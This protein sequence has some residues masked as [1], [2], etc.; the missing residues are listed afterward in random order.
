MAII[1]QNFLNNSVDSSELLDQKNIEAQRMQDVQLL[2]QNLSESEEATIKLILDCLYDIGS[3]NLINQRFRYRPFNRVVKLIARMSKP[4]FRVYGWYWFK[5]NCPQLIANWLHSQVAF[6]YIVNTP[7][8][9]AVEVS[10]IQQHQPLPLDNYSLEVKT[11]RNQIKWLTGITIVSLSILGIVFTI[12]NSN[13]QIILQ[14]R[15]QFQPTICR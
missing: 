10:A 11:L 3:V 8:Q 4:I 14:K 1:K 5:K 13:P 7:Q 9:I 15:T 6:E 2:L 12:F